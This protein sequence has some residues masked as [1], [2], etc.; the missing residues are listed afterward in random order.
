MTLA[1]AAFFVIQRGSPR[2]LRGLV[3]PGLHA[4][5]RPAA[6]CELLDEHRQTFSLPGCPPFVFINAGAHGYYRSGYGSEALGRI[7]AAAG[8]LTAAEQVALL[9]DSWALVRVGR[10]GIG[11]YLAL[12]EGLKG[13]RNLT[14][15]GVL[16]G[17][18]QSFDSFL[19]EDDLPAYRRWLRSVLEP[20]IADLTFSVRPG[21]SDDRATLRAVVFA[22]LGEADDPQAISV[23]N[24]LPP[25]RS[26]PR[27]PSMPSP[28]RRPADRR[29][30]TA[31]PRSTHRFLAAMQSAKTP[32]QAFRLA[33]GLGLVQAGCIG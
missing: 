26:V 27:R 3:H 6:Q 16:L 31:T 29:A 28:E 22:A 17:R 7:A 18:L 19:A 32:E 4:R 10:V 5:Q 1:A 30:R 2:L 9:E 13:S 12:A 24:R 8:Q 33:H 14:V 20:A 15:A 25:R 23:A 11:D 21:E